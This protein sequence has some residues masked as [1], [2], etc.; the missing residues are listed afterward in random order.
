MLA[1]QAAG[2][3]CTAC[4]DCSTGYCVDGKCADSPGGTAAACACD[5]ACGSGFCTDGV[6]C[7]TRCDGTCQACTAVAKQAGNDGECG[8]VAPA[9]DPDSECQA[10]C[11]G[12]GV[13]GDQGACV[14]APQGSAT[15]V[16]SQLVTE[17]STVDCAPYACE[18]GQCKNACSTSADCAGGVP[19]N[20]GK[21]G[22]TA[23]A[24]NSDDGGCGCRAERTSGAGSGLLAALS[25]LLL[26]S[27]RRRR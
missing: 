24:S 1:A 7:D 27:L 26:I 25:L 23:A 9:T 22:G 14:C 16:G 10:N 3:A 12:A 17:S 13:C 2:G 8:P 20:G 6:C 19:C 15:C 5:A 11:A 4:S 21:C 18:Q